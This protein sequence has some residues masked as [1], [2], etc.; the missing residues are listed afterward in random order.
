MLKSEREES[1]SSFAPTG[2]VAAQIGKV[3]RMTLGQLAMLFLR[4][5]IKI[6]TV[7]APDTK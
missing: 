2:A 4:F 7:E 3:E 1:R 5:R 6:K